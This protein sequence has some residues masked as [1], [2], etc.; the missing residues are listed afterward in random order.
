[1]KKTNKQKSQDPVKCCLQKTDFTYEATNRWN[2]WKN[3]EKGRKTD[4]TV[5]R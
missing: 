4:R 1:M 5:P 2:G 3:G